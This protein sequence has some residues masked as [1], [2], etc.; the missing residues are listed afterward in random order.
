IPVVKTTY[1]EVLDLPEPEPGVFYIVS[2][3]VLSAVGDSRQ[4]LL[5]PDTGPASVVRDGDGK[6][7]GVRRLRR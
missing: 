7:V 4:D 2:G 5:A 3:V 6:I 1:G